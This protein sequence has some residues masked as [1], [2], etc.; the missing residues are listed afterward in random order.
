MAASNSM[1]E[2]ETGTEVVRLTSYLFLVLSDL[3]WPIMAGSLVHNSFSVLFV[4]CFCIFSS[5]NASRKKRKEKQGLK[6]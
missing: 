5:I 3:E 1:N 6:Y 2:A 4:T